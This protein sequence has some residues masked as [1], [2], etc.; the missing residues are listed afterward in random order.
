[1]RLRTPSGGATAAP[2]EPS[3]ADQPVGA[4][5]EADLLLSKPLTGTVAS[6]SLVVHLRLRVKKR[7]PIANHLFNRL[8]RIVCYRKP[9]TD[10]NGV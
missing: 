8:G 9:R 6:V 10:P 4:N 2:P 1:M 3:Y 5:G 7:V